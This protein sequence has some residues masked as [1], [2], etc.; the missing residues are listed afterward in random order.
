MKNEFEIA[1]N[2]IAE[3][4]ALP[5]DVVLEALQTALVS[6]YQRDTNA[7]KAQHVEATID[8]VTGRARIFVEKE[9]VE[10]VENPNT[11]VDLEKARYYHPE[12]QLGDTVMVQ[13]EGTTKKFGRI[14]AQTAKQVILQ[15]IREAERSSLYEEYKDKEGD[16]VNGTVQ[17]IAA[18]KV[19]IGLGR[20]EAELMRQ[21]QIPGERYR[22]H[23]KVRCYVLEVKKSNRGPQ[24]ILS[25][26]HRNMLR[27]LLEFEVPEIYNG[28][29][30]IKNIARE[31]GYRS[32][33]AV[34][35]LQEG[36]D[37]VGACV[38][39]R[40]I[41]IQNIVNELNKEKIDVIEWNPNQEEFIEKAL[42][43][44]RVTG[45]FLDDDPDYGRTA[46]V[47]VRD[48]QLSLAI[49]KEGQNARL[50]AK[51]TGW[52]IDIKSVTESVSSALDNIDRHPLD[53][54]MVQ[55][56]ELLSNAIMIME[57]KQAGRVLT[58]EEFKE[59]SR[60]SVLAERRYVEVRN[61]SRAARIAEINAVKETLPQAYFDI[62]IT[63]LELPDHMIEALEPLGNTGEI[64]LRFLIDETR[65]KRLLGTNNES[66][67]RQV[68]NALDKLVIPD[69]GTAEED[70]PT[71]VEVVDFAPL[72][73]TE[74]LDTLPVVEEIPEPI[75][76][77][78]LP[79]M[80]SDTPAETKQKFPTAEVATEEFFDLDDDDDDSPR[81]IEKRKKEKEKRRQLVYDEDTGQTFAKRRRKGGRKTGSWDG[82]DF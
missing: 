26:S 39:M 5:Q 76:E 7:S 48:D 23:D 28:Q 22:Q 11:E 41:R 54:L 15:K 64:M 44:A 75:N 12:C 34:M 80:M 72:E 45:V 13:L 58:E 31:A 14:A 50:A 68:Q 81:G 27:R 73:M 66:A 53:V 10:E 82:E 62:P 30:E 20:A 16:I 4:R 79:V 17:S 40:G 21:H 52:R 36:I 74:E 19:T 29:I 25:R 56:P 9:V 51:L 3:L 47:V 67:L 60:F 24:I 70:A 43:P 69:D 57:K 37:P 1:F 77:L 35:A 49:G 42:S 32:K 18:N 33:V 59:L 63:A 71:P 8:P 6:A 38:G 65:L 2:E 46:V 55:N 61:Q 78:P